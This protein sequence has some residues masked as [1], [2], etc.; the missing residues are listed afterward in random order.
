MHVLIDYTQITKGTVGASD[1]DGG[2]FLGDGYTLPVFVPAS[3]VESL[4]ASYDPDN[5]YSPAAADSRNLARE[6]LAALKKI[7][8]EEE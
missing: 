8:E 3:E 4:L 2:S 5:Q 6:I 1:T 7:T